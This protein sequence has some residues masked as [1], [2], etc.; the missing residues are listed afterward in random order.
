[1]DASRLSHI[2][3]ASSPLVLNSKLGSSRFARPASG[4]SSR[5]GRPS[6]AGPGRPSTSGRS[7]PNFSTACQVSARKPEGTTLS[8]LRPKNTWNYYVSEPPTV[9]WAE[10][11]STK[12]DASGCGDRC[13]IPD[14]IVDVLKKMWN[15]ST[16][17]GVKYLCV[18]ETCYN[19]EEHART[20]MHKSGQYQ[21]Y[22]NMVEQ[23]LCSDFPFVSYEQF[24]LSKAYKACRPPPR[25]VGAFELYLLYSP[26]G[27][28]HCVNFLAHSK[29]VS[30]RWPCCDKLRDRL[31]QALP[32]IVSRVQEVVLDASAWNLAEGRQVI[33]EA[34]ALGL[35]NWEPL[36][37]LT[38]RVAS[39]DCCLELG[40]EAMA[41]ND[42]ETLR[43]ALQQ[44]S[45]LQLSD[46][47]IAGWRQDLKEKNMAIF[48]M[49]S[50][51]RRFCQNAAFAIAV[52]KLQAAMVPPLRLAR[53]VDAVQRGRAAEVAEED[54]LPAVDAHGR[55]SHAIDELRRALQNYNLL[56]LSNS[57]QRLADMNVEDENIDRARSE[58]GRIASRVQCAVQ[59]QDLVWLQDGLGHWQIS[60][61]TPSPMTH[62][63]IIG[64]SL[65]SIVGGEKMR[66]KLQG[67][68]DEAERRY[69]TKQWKALKS[70]VE[71]LNDV[72]VDENTW[73]RWLSALKREDNL[74]LI[75]SVSGAGRELKRK[76]HGSRLQAALKAERISLEQLEAAVSDAEAHSV[77]QVDVDRA[78]N[79][80]AGVRQRWRSAQEA[81]EKKLVDVAEVNLWKL[82]KG[83]IYMDEWTKKEGPLFDLVCAIRDAEATKDWQAMKAAVEGWQE[84]KP[85]ANHPAFEAED[86]PTRLFRTAGS[87]GDELQLDELRHEVNDVL[88]SIKDGSQADPQA[89]LRK[90]AQM[91]REMLKLGWEL[92]PARSA[93]LLSLSQ[94]VHAEGGLEASIARFSASMLQVLEGSPRVVFLLDQSLPQHAAEFKA[95]V[96]A[97]AEGFCRHVQ[98]AQWAVVVYGPVQVVH[99][100][101]SDPNV[102]NAAL[103]AHSF[104]A[105]PATAAQGLRA[106]KDAFKEEKDPRIILHLTNGAAENLKDARKAFQVIEA[107]GITVLGICIGKASK[108]DKL[109]KISSS[110][111]AFK[112]EEPAQ[113]VA[114]VRDALNEVDSML[115]VSQ[116]GDADKVLGMLEA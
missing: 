28:N 90:A 16:K 72:H 61:D 89:E 15:D 70:A 24:H 49:K 35:A 48:N 101:T 108:V 47:A 53:L 51:A 41:G 29:F 39:A 114:F 21:R 62:D 19:C 115:Q 95:A 38:D 1:M 106:A 5:T 110:G 79:E 59:L 96:A 86:S 26:Y 9:S 83:R 107:L 71:K 88:N 8:N 12:V 50:H 2:S 77:D 58:L 37:D 81:M 10:Q 93:R 116:A 111:L 52:R 40:Q 99:D 25:R 43:G 6:S 97:M 17:R 7:R 105:G 30:L 87:R 98:G 45:E 3:H 34:T 63:Q 74:S 56:E 27:N 80:A 94:K 14:S 68:V 73:E 82:Q 112:V 100:S 113:L 13:S 20:T 18:L 60:T 92:T 46:D 104:S 84:D 33:R 66:L 22:A 102:L 36:N 109:M 85:G 23:M 44:V 64:S 75:K 11:W 76:L 54:L 78:R 67:R 103:Q 65:R 91:M 69:E 31:R 42:K 4:G 55:V 32:A 57:M